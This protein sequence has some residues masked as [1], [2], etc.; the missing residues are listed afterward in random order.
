MALK[1]APRD[2]AHIGDDE[3][4]IYTAQEGLD[5]ILRLS[6]EHLTSGSLA[7]NYIQIIR[8]CLFPV[9]VLPSRVNESPRWMRQEFHPAAKIGMD[10]LIELNRVEHGKKSKT[11]F[12]VVGRLPSIYKAADKGEVVVMPEVLI[13]EEVRFL[14]THGNV[15]RLQ[16]PFVQ[17]DMVTYRLTPEDLNQLTGAEQDLATI[18][19]QRAKTATWAL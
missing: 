11:S 19:K 3:Y 15:L 5:A 6:T 1:Q 4:Y 7:G 13:K 2:K 16:L 9:R 17:P 8:P 12:N 18:V 14:F 10:G